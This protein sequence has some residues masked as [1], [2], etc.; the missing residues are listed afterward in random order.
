MAPSRVAQESGLTA[1]SCTFAQ[2]R[3]RCGCL[4]RGPPAPKTP[5]GSAKDES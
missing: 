4:T 5:W 3:E 1:A 2:A